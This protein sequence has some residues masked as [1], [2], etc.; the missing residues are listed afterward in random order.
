V[1]TWPDNTKNDA[2]LV[3]AEGQQKLSEHLHLQG[4]A[5]LRHGLRE[6]FNGDASE[7]QFCKEGSQE[8]CDADGQPLRTETQ[9]PVVAAVPYDGLYNRTDTDSQAYGGSV[10][11]TANGPLGSLDNSLIAGASY[12]GA[13]SAFL[14][15]AELGYVTADRTILGQ[16]QFLAGDE[17]R[18]ELEA[19]NQ[20]LG[21]YVSDTLSVLDSLAITASARFNWARLQLDDQTGNA[22]DGEHAYA[23]INPAFGVTFTPLPAITVFASYGESNRAPSASELACADPDAPCRLPNAFITDPALEQVVSRSIELG[24]RARF[25]PRRA[26]LLEGSFA[27]F[28]ARNSDDILFVAGSHVGT[29]YFRNAGTTQ[30]IGLE[31]GLLGTAGPLEWYASYTLLRASFESPLTL[32]AADHPQAEDGVIEVRPGD[33]IPGLPMHSVKAGVTVA[34][35]PRLRIGLSAIAQSSQPFRG[36][37]ANLLANLDGFVT[38]NAHASYELFDALRLLL[39][40]QNLLNNEYETFGVIADPS[41][42]L[43]RAHDPRF[44]SP[45]PPFGIWMG[46][47]LHEPH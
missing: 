3:V 40:A 23:R 16:N 6:T 28:G 29:G 26:P 2:L 30:R 32:P 33:R 21:V 24:L 43:P 36:D 11:L 8:L 17:F 18:T 44:V 4:T 31:L 47:E 22:L 37:E 15:R 10:Q 20:L 9:L 41:D 42:V 45:G 5:Y 27:L 34:P 7:T 14:Q 35:L 12:D 39:K 13:S 1:F 38:L 46:V 25:G 19:W